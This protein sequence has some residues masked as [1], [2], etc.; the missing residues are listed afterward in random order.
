MYFSDFLVVY[1]LVFR[2]HFDRMILRVTHDQLSWS[3]QMSNDVHKMLEYIEFLLNTK[4]SYFNLLINSRLSPYKLSVRRYFLEA[5]KCIVLIFAYLNEIFLFFINEINSHLALTLSERLLKSRMSCSVFWMW[6]KQCFLPMLN[7]LMLHVG[8][9]I[10]IVYKNN[11][12]LVC[13]T[14]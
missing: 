3:Y 7:V 4:F 2:R 14:L 13:T 5:Y 6:R 10:R 11:L 12:Y 1:Y 8:L 9:P